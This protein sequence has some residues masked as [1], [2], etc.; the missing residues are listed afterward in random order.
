MYIRCLPPILHAK[1]YLNLAFKK[2]KQ[3]TLYA[4][5]QEHRDELA[6]LQC[7]M[8][9]APVP[10]LP[11]PMGHWTPDADGCG[12]HIYRVLMQKQSNKTK[13]HL[14]LSGGRWLQYTKTMVHTSELLSCRVCCSVFMAVCVE[15]GKFTVSADQGPLNRSLTSLTLLEHWSIDGSDYS[16]LMSISRIEPQ[17]RTRL[18]TQ[19]EHS[20]TWSKYNR[21]SRCLTKSDDDNF[22]P[23]WRN[24]GMIVAMEL[25]PILYFSAVWWICENGKERITGVIQSANIESVF[26]STGSR[27]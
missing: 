19:Y 3:K 11:K 15:G 20:K 6:P 17:S 12:K 16:N 4:V 9:L 1:L 22:W 23:T 8:V 27:S 5:T 14:A 18:L 7:K 10:I 24:D 13:H 21:I 26:A 2:S 25:Q